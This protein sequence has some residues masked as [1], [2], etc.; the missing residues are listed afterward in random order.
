MENLVGWEL[1]I[2]ILGGV[3]LSILTGLLKTV[4]KK[5]NPQYIVLGLALLLGILYQAFISF[6]P[7]ELQTEIITFV[8]GTLSSAVLVYE[9]VWKN[10]AG[11]E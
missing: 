6:V 7:V 3:L 11:R 4:L 5:L 9:F 1:I 8:Y 10:L 2:T